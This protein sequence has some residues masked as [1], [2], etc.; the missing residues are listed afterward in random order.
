M[1]GT[2]SV[3]Q[4]AATVVSTQEQQNI[5]KSGDT[6]NQPS[7]VVVS[8]PK[9]SGAGGGRGG[10]GGVNV[11]QAEELNRNIANGVTK[12][13]GN[14]TKTYA[15]STNPLDAYASYT[16]GL[17]LHVLTR[18]DYNT[19][20][21]NP[22]AFRPTKTLISSAGRYQDTRDPEF[23][24]DF[25]F[26]DLKFDTV[27]G[28]N[29]NARGTNVITVDFTIIEPYGMT[30]LDR[31]INVNNV[32]LNGKNYLEMP[33]LLEISFFGGDDK[34]KM[35]KIADQTKWIPIKLTGFKIKASVKGAEYHIS[36]V[37]FNHA[38]NLET[39]QSI[40]TRMHVTAS[41]VGDYFSMSSDTATN[42][43]ITAAID[44]ETK[45]QQKPAAT[46]PV[47]HQSVSEANANT[48]KNGPVGRGGAR[49]YNTSNATSSRVPAKATSSSATDNNS[50]AAS[51]QPIT[52]NAKS[53]VAAYNG[54]FGAEYKKGNIGQ[55]DIIEVRFDESSAKEISN[56]TIV[57]AKKNS[58][59]RVGETDAKTAAKSTSGKEAETAKFDSIVHDLDPGSTINDVLNTVLSQSKFFLD[60]VVDSST[61]NKDPKAKSADSATTQDQA[62]PVKMWKIIPSIQL[63]KFD[64]ERNQW[65]KRITFFVSLYTA[66]QNRDD[67]LPKSPPPNPVKKYDYFYTGHNSSVINFDIDFNALYFTAYNADRGATTAAAGT[68]QKPEDNANKDKP[69]SNAD[70]HQ[71]GQETRNITSGNQSDAA[72]GGA[73]RS[74]TQNAR[75]AL[76]SI[77]TS[78]AGDMINLKMQII[79]DPEF[80]KQDDIFI[81]PANLLSGNAPND[82]SN[83]YVPGTKSIDM[84][85][86][87][88][89]CYVTF[90]TPKDFND[91]NGMYD[92]NSSNKY[93]VSEFSGFYKI[94]KVGNEFR[95]GKFT[96]TLEMIRQPKQDPINKSKSSNSD[97]VST[98]DAQRKEETKQLQQAANP[99]VS[100]ADASP[101]PAPETQSQPNPA[102][103]ASKGADGD[104]A[105]PQPATATSPGIT[106]Q[107]QSPLNTN[108][109][110]FAPPPQLAGVANS[111]KTVAIGDSP[112][113]DS[114]TKTTGS[115]SN[116]NATQ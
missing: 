4:A 101:A 74:E 82:P 87:E 86:S 10:Q 44:E 22:K 67:R 116:S 39:V 88:I 18:E 51:T 11:Q 33:Y 77:Y 98:G 3:G 41:T 97:V 76:Q 92:L 50:K 78:A 53:F 110:E 105:A 48:A 104:A 59:R 45:R 113:S 12:V 7:A 99:A 19:M 24:D 31:I 73:Q 114:P 1:A 17:T 107:F 61:S 5:A 56:S 68:S 62:K 71:I 112:P 115:D 58:V 79:G 14:Q 37:P 95:G 46:P 85:S 102:D 8:G 63:L 55:P 100:A 16:Y 106:E 108:N 13:G 34:G 96:Q 81:N 29:A 30:L 64:T 9:Y 40:K 28:L 54:W 80:I 23:K 57:D 47:A 69:D 93:S 89:Y 35:Q 2:T 38:A 32:G 25:Y 66:Y 91:S 52:V 60:Q 27:I 72:G 49:T 109:K 70:Q 111:G 36:G 6:T 84:D 21:S 90:R 65:A 20:V 15:P 43:S 83:P 75:S 42:D 103:K 94:I 26:E